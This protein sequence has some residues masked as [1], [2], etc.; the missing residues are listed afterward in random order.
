MSINYEI[1]PK[2]RRE[3]QKSKGWGVSVSR[4]GNIK[5]ACEQ[6]DHY[7]LTCTKSFEPTQSKRPS[8]FP[9]AIIKSMLLLRNAPHFISEACAH[10]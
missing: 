5:L 10:L 1:P 6:T 9:L 8:M 3:W 2:Q 4:A 7:T